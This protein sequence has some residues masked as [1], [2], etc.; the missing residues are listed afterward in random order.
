M[1]PLTGWKTHA[2][3]ELCAW[4]SPG[5]QS[6]GQTAGS[7]RVP[8]PGPWESTMMGPSLPS[9]PGTHY[10]GWWFRSSEFIQA[11]RQNVYHLLALLLLSYFLLIW[12]DFPRGH[13][14]RPQTGLQRLLTLCS[15]SG[16]PHLPNPEF[17]RGALQGTLSQTVVHERNGTSMNI[18]P[19]AS[20]CHGFISSLE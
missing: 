16:M 1:V 10:S 9:S 3:D 19:G 11:V 6:R 14:L 8:G 17:L 4:T 5:G 15:S 2:H 18:Q 13:L 12:V 7:T 20:V